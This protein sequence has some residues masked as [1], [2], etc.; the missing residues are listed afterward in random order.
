MSNT[1]QYEKVSGGSNN[2]RWEPHKST[3]PVY[4]EKNPA[5]LEGYY[6]RTMQRNGPE[7]PFDVHEIQTIVENKDKTVELSEVFDVSL[8]VGLSNTLQNVKQGSFIC[9]LYKGKKVSDKTKRTFNDTEVMNDP[10]AIPYK[11][12]SSAPE[13]ALPATNSNKAQGGKDVPAANNPFP[14]DLDD[15]PFRYE[16]MKSNL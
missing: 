5:T 1:R 12:L 9:I 10:N 16:K 8:G 4:D 3:N 7:G 15:L 6:L 14:E 11:D 13:M 2:R